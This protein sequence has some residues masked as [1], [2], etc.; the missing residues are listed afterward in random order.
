[1]SARFTRRFLTPFVRRFFTP[2]VFSLAALLAACGTQQTTSPSAPSTRAATAAATNGATISGTVVGISSPT[3]VWTTHGATMT[4]AVTGTTIS[5]PVDA[6]GRFVLQSVPPGRVD[7]HFSGDGVDAHLTLDG[8]TE[9]ATV[10]ITV[11]VIGS[12]AQLEDDRQQ[13]GAG[14]VELEGLVTA[15]GTGTL[16][17]AGRIVNVTTATEIVHGDTHVALSAIHIGDRVHVKGTAASNTS[18]VDA[19]KIE[20]QNPAGK[21]DTGG[22]DDQGGNA[23]GQVEVEGTI[24][25]NSFAGS[26][27]ANSLSFKVGAATIRTNQA[28]Q[29]K[30][31]TC[32]ALTAGDGVEVSG[33]KQ[34]DSS[35][36]A[37][38]VEKE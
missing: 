6:S 10:T 9:N 15:T 27:Q 32:A 19:A 34:T 8:I 16:T 2:L 18:A 12:S 33:T 28:T 29:F 3:A 25:V 21:P 30:D 7:L 5:S 20:V 38:R 11:R 26:C 1:M 14:K 22:G 17:V 31:T 4:V 13:D 23:S 24:V 35:V 36:L 37:S